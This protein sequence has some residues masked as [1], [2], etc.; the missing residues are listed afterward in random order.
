MTSL[1]YSIF[2][3]KVLIEWILGSDVKV[4]LWNERSF[5]DGS[6]VTETQN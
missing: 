2:S 4:I 1:E 3:M 5:T 6:K